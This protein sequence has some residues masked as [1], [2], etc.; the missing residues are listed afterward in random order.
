MKSLGLSLFVVLVLSAQGE[1]VR[2][3][4]QVLNT[5]F[6]SEGCA[7]GDVN[8]DGKVDVLAGAYWYEAPGW[9]PHEIHYATPVIPNQGYQKSF[10]NASMDVNQDGWTDQI[11]VGFPGEPVLWFENPKRGRGHWVSHEIH[12]SGCNESPQTGDID[13]DGRLDLLFAYAPENQM[14][15]F[16]PPITPG[17]GAFSR[18][19]ISGFN[20][21]GTDRYSHG[22]GVADING[23]G[24][25]DVMVTEGWWEGPIDPK[26]GEWTFHPAPFGPACA[27]MHGY[28]F[29]ADGDTDLISSSAHNYGIWWQEQGKDDKG[30]TTWTQHE[31]Y[32]KVSQTHSLAFADI[33]RDGLPD[34]ITGKRFFAHNGHDPG[35]FEPAVLFWLEFTRKEG[36]P[37]WAYHP[38]D[39]DSG[40][41]TQFVVEDI[42]GDGKLDIVTSNKKGTYVFLQE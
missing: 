41:G 18:H 1:E 42:T 36:K 30:E 17:E 6:Y 31:I 7:V 16:A 10:I 38:I 12:P 23:D 13:S 19:P 3:Q 27:H 32:S 8:R 20:A 39:S 9:A 4:K 21:P 35:A 29:D 34:L 28:D 33:N 24:R 26:Q 40:V 5:R 25:N 15:W 37:T 2:F 11:V 22:L 14:A